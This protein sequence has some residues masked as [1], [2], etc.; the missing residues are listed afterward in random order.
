MKKIQTDQSG[1]GVVEIILS[2]VIVV[3]VSGAGW[4][5]WK[6]NQNATNSYNSAAS[7]STVTNSSNKP[8]STKTTPETEVKTEPTPT[9]EPTP[10]PAKTVTASKATTFTAANCTGNI[11]V[12][13]SN[14]AGAEGSYNPS[15]WT[16][17]KTFAY[18]EAISAFC[19]SNT[20]ASY[21]VT[22][23]DMYVKRSDLS[24]TKP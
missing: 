12:Y 2:F 11:T 3:M 16:V 7:T 15:S 18:G 21:V 4:Y 8:K 24:P 19:D 5:V 9:P 1:F 23:S 20:L 17:V 13:V 6:S 14:K 22:T 10:A